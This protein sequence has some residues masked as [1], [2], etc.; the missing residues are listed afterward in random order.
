MCLVQHKHLRSGTPAH[1]EESD[2]RHLTNHARMCIY[3]VM[4]SYRDGNKSVRILGLDSLH[5]SNQ[6]RID[7]YWA[8]YKC[9]CSRN[10]E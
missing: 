5:L 9:R 10:L 1:T 3:S 6:P 4:Y 2:N 7:T 8:P